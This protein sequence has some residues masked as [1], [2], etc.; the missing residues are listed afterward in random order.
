MSEV[1]TNASDAR[2]SYDE[3][4][5]HMK[6]HLARLASRF[7]VDVADVRQTLYVVWKRVAQLSG[8]RHTEDRQAFYKYL[9]RALENERT[10]TIGVHPPCSNGMWE[11]RAAAALQD[12]DARVGS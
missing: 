3:A 8:G 4:L 10:D 9:Y 1:Q 11:D 7:R 2:A 5:A 6:G 12:A